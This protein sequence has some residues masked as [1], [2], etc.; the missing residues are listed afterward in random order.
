VLQ[1][2]R[3]NIESAIDAHIKQELKYTHAYF[4]D[5][6]GELLGYSNDAPQKK[7]LEQVSEDAMA[8]V[9]NAMF[10]FKL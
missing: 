1:S 7:A 2:A 10:K 6:V 8:I 3:A 5:K 9:H 4:L